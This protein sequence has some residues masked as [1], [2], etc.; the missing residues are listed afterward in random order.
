MAKFTG[1]KS[2][3]ENHGHYQTA[4]PICDIDAWRRTHTNLRGIDRR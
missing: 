3:V 1:L 2:K 4:R